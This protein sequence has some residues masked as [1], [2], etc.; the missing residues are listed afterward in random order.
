MIKRNKFSILLVILI[1]YL[2]LTSS[3]TFKRVPEL[4]IPHLDKIVHLGMYF[5]LMLIIAFENRKYIK[6]PLNMLLIGIIPLC[7]GILIELIQSYLTSSRYGSA[8]DAISNMAGII[9][10]VLLWCW[11]KPSTKSESDSC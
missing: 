6:S 3:D 9:L 2:S 5:S 10:A 8:F 7:Y 1:T 4:H 11:I